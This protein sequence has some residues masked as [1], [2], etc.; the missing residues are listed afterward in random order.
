MSSPSE[1]V[2]RALLRDWGLPDPG[3]SK[4][5]RGRVIVVG[6][7]R[8]AP[9]AALLAGE[10]ALRVGAG[11]LG[12]VVPRSIDGQLGVT[13]PE[14][15]VFAMPDDAGDTFDDVVLTELESADAVLLGPG[16]DDAEQTLATLRRVGSVGVRCLVLDAFALGILSEVPRSELPAALIL[17]PNKEEAAILLGRDLGN[18]PVADVSEIARRF[19]AIVNCYGTVATPTGR[20][21]QVKVGGP[22]LGT[23][24]SGDVLAGAIAGFAARGGEPSRA[25]VW[26]SW[27][28]ARAGDRLAARTGIGFLAREIATELTPTLA[29]TIG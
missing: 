19:D 27:T 17:N 24:G 28:H 6:G 23:S 10:A 22:G 4:K 8:R 9:G 21:W 13:M 15:A 5:S 14:A 2:T 11:R 16:F 12:L 20:T 3:D 26:G 1:V 29:E 25:A 7:S 18:D